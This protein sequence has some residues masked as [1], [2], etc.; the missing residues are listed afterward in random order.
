MVNRIIGKMVMFF[1]RWFRR[2]PVV[3]ESVSK[4]KV[5]RHKWPKGTRGAPGAFG[6]SL[7]LKWIHTRGPRPA[8][9]MMRVDAELLR[10]ARQRRR[11]IRR[12]IAAA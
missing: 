7:Y 10:W 3:I 6:S 5:E 11:K 12:W 4:P 8:M 1:K 2:K 9:G